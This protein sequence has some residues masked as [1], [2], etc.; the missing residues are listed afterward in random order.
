MR[1]SWNTRISFGVGHF[2]NDLTA[3]MWFTYLLVY[4]QFVLCFDT[5]VSGFVLL[6]GQVTDAIATP[7]LGYET[8]SSHHLGI[9]KKY[10][11]RKV[12]YLFG[13]SCVLF[14]FPFI[15]IQ[16]PGC[17]NSSQWAMVVYLVPLVVIFQTG[18]AAVQVSHLAL[19]PVITDDSSE[20]DFL[21]VIRNAFDAVA[22]FSV[23]TIAWIIFV[24]TVN[25]PTDALSIAEDDKT[26]FMIIVMTI[27]CI[28][29]STC[30]IFYLGVKEVTPVQSS[31]TSIVQRRTLNNRKIFKEKEFYKIAVIYTTARLFQNFNLVF[32]PLYLQ[33]SLG[34]TQD[35]I[36]KI[37]LLIHV[38]GFA[39]SFI[40]RYLMK[41]CG[42]KLS[43]IFG[44][45]IGTGGCTWIY[46]GEGPSF[47]SQ[48]IYVV[49]ILLGIGSSILVVTSL[50]LIPDFIGLDT[51]IG[52]FVYGVISFFDKLANGIGILII[53][54][55]HDIMCDKCDWFY[56][57]IMSIGV[58]SIGVAMVLMILLEIKL[59]HRENTCRKRFIAENKLKN[60]F[61]NN[62][63][64]I[65]PLLR[66][67][68]M[69]HFAL[70]SSEC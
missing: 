54:Y 42:K 66:E 14:S 46:F 49:A 19:I 5:G 27:I 17:S 15:F 64:E 70:H 31:T 34:A 28:G 40:T 13:V 23:F 30:V 1:L 59:I 53:Q 41:F 57:H 45:V 63:S 69:T 21:N 35:F 12:L 33:E 60:E 26:K 20:R 51:D 22:D 47:C 56:R 10:G 24:T 52:T 48:Y 68:G 62:K 25:G 67:N 65:Q 38:A 11:R 55:L 18:W 36:A 32:I 2:L 61:V 8:D 50:A 29:F 39:S 37:P 9:C 16:C 44:A 6:V 4:L 3:S 58:G 7:L 43:L